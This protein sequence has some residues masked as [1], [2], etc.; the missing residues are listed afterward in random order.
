MSNS[1]TIVR[2]GS[3]AALGRIWTA[4]TTFVMMP[5][6]LHAL[7]ADGFGLWQLFL[8]IIFFLGLF[9]IGVAPALAKY[10]SEYTAS[11]DLEHRD[12]LINGAYMFYAGLALLSLVIGMACTDAYLH[13]IHTP[14]SM[15]EAARV[16]FR[17]VVVVTSVV[18]LSSAARAILIGVQRLDVINAIEVIVNTVILGAVVWIAMTSRSP[19]QAL[20]RMG[21]VQFAQFSLISGILILYALRLTPGYRFQP[22]RVAKAEF[23][24]L[25]GYGWKASAMSLSQ[26]AQTQTEWFLLARILGPGP[27]A[28][29]S[30]GARIADVWKSVV[31]PAFNAVLA[32][33]SAMSVT[34]GLEAVRR[35]YDRG[36]RIVNALVIGISVWLVVVAPILITAWM[37][38]GYGMSILALRVLAVAAGAW[39]AA[40]M[41][42]YVG[43]GVNVMRPGIIA[44]VVLAVLQFGVGLL[45]GEL[46]GYK[47]LLAATCLSFI[48]YA[49]TLVVLTHR[50]FRWPVLGPLLQLYLLPTLLAAAAAAPLLWYNHVHRAAIVHMGGEA[51]RVLHLGVMGLW[52]TIAF[53]A[54]YALVIALSRYITREDVVSLRAAVKGMRHAHAAPAAEARAESFSTEA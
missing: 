34:D 6:L 53:A 30:F 14:E 22:A 48:V 27:V 26:L 13:F 42:G 29:Y 35:L 20:V 52:Q 41:A 50:A 28:L 39:L 4:A 36:T 8:R 9:E 15:M 5:L 47:G 38:K 3:Y 10:V 25:F 54:I 51:V 23:R 1:A 16:S 2:N 33:A 31:M 18:V 12:R 43:R 44:G 32:G 46:Y 49:V 40:G 11:G 21:V 45:L 37:G 19:Q 24:Q 17:W 7:G